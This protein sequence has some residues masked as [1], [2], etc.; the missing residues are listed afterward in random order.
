LAEEVRRVT[1]LTIELPRQWTAREAAATVAFEWGAMSPPAD[2]QRGLAWK[3]WRDGLQRAVRE[4]LVEMRAMQGGDKYNGWG[5]SE[6]RRI[7]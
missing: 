1:Q 5:Y 7:R 4:G 6:W 3:E 2:C